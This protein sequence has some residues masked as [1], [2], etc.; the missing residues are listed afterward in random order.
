MIMAYGYFGLHWLS[1]SSPYRTNGRSTGGRTRSCNDLPTRR[2]RFA[3]R[4]RLRSLAQA[5]WQSCDK[6]R[7]RGLGARA[8]FRLG[9][10]LSATKRGETARHGVTEARENRGPA[11]H[12]SRL[13]R[14][15]SNFESLCRGASVAHDSGVC[16]AKYRISVLFA[17]LSRAIRP[18]ARPCVRR[19]SP[20]AASVFWLLASD[21]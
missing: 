3:P 14:G 20:T 15:R 10:A 12:R 17:R 16:V 8:S 9:Q 7:M 11:Q 18:P 5:L 4:Q 6:G 13:Q 2:P 1:T 21:S 19:R